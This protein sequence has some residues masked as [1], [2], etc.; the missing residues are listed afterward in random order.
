MISKKPIYNII[1]SKRKLILEKKEFCKSKFVVL[2]VYDD[3]SNKFLV[4][5][6]CLLFERMSNGEYYVGKIKLI[7]NIGDFDGSEFINW[8]ASFC[9]KSFN[10]HDYDSKYMKL[11]Y[12]NE[13]GTKEIEL[14]LTGCIVSKPNFFPLDTGEYY[15][16]QI[17]FNLSFKNVFYNHVGVL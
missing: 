8:V 4:D 1:F 12:Y 3:Q 15:S 13:Y 10:I 17:E 16:P 5:K 14:S 11:V 9:N 2:H 7:D 6:N